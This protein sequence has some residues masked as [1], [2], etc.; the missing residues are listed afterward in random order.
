MLEQ[1]LVNKKNCTKYFGAEVLFDKNVE[2]SFWAPDAS[3]VKLCIQ[4]SDGSFDEISM[5][6][7]NDGLYKLVTNQAKN[8]TLYCYK[9]DNDLMVPDLASR[10]QPFDIKGL[11]QVIDPEEFEW[12]NDCNWKGRPWE[13]TVLYELHTGTFTKEGTFKALEE[14][15]DYFVSLG[16]TAIELMP[17]ADFPGKRNWGYDGVL[18]YAPDSSYGTP[19]ELKKLI[20]TAH[21]KGIMVFLDVVYNHFGPDGNYLYV[22]AKSKFFDTARK[23]PWGD[24]INFKNKYVRE[25]FIN[26]AIYWLKEFHFDG[27]RFD[28]VH[29]INDGSTP[30]ILDE[31]ASRAKEAVGDDRHIHLVLE[32]DDNEAKYLDE[33]QGGNYCA[34]WNDDFHH[35]AHIFITGED[36]GYYEDYAKIKTKKPTSYFMA[37]ILSEGFA[38]QGE[39]SPHRLNKLRGEKSS[40]LSPVKFVNFIQNHDQIGNRAFGERLSLLSDKNAIMAAASL[41]LLAPSIPL[42]FMGEEWNSKTPFC[43]FCNFNEELSEA[44]KKG[45]RE[46]F[47]KFPQ[48][49]DPKIRESIPDPSAQKTYLDSKL[50]FDDLELPEN[51][52]MLAFYKKLLNIRK[53]HIIK[54]IKNIKNSDFEI[55]N[56]KAFKVNWNLDSKN[57]KKLIV[58]ANFDNKP[59]EITQKFEE[60]DILFISN[61]QSKDTLINDKLLLPKTVL[62]FLT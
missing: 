52:E 38:Y 35:C 32:N 21:E 28:A 60:K 5:E 36:D 41:Y 19:D 58:I 16:I 9:I 30:D 47:S 17:V 18:I 13:E 26:N 49:S 62:W 48:F 37:R 10:Y 40:H 8:G 24:A 27:L 51:K 45:R 12:G 61:V 55:I 20:K 23:T 1:N 15:L 11:S 42:L 33:V 3:D 4:K 29:A 31:I 53:T 39:K 2:F 59:I 44:V 57:E 14:K 22:Y 46:E 25:F 6:A 50:N 7:N 56:D 34:Q 54:I 43:F